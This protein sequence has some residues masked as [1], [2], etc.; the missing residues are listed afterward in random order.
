L[1]VVLLASVLAFSSLASSPAA[2][3]ASVE[4]SPSCHP[5]DLAALQTS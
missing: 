4:F 5:C 3:V 1:L 2:V